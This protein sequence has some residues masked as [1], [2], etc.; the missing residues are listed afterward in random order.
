MTEFPKLKTGAVA[1]HP[2]TRELRFATEAHRFLDMSEQRFRDY[3]ASRR[4]WF[5]DL[6]LLDE[7]ELSRLAEFFVDMRGSFGEFEFEDPW[8]GALVSQCRFGEDLLPMRQDG[9]LDSSASLTVVE[10]Q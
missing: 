4:R 6:S 10:V 9:E 5:V 8:D 3:S 2:A 1:Q 7:M